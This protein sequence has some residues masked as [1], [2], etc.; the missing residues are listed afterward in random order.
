MGAGVE[1]LAL[2]ACNTANGSGVG[3]T[4]AEIEGL[5]VVA[6][7]KGASAVIASLWAVSD[8]ST[9]ALMERFYQL[10]QSAPTLNKTECLR[11]AQLALLRGE[12]T[13][14]SKALRGNVKALRGKVVE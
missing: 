9:A 7:R 5:G 2:S 12:V 14:D 4:G 10:R 1:V 3:D 13:L 11:R 8:A 6:Q